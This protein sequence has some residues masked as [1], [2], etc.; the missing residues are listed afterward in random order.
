METHVLITPLLSQKA[1]KS[2][3]CVGEAA[4]PYVAP[5]SA[6][7]RQEQGAFPSRVMPSAD[8]VR[9]RVL[10][11]SDTHSALPAPSD[12]DIAYR[13]PLPRADV[14]L[15]AGDL[16]M[17]GKI[18]QHRKALELIKG[19]DAELKIVI[20]GNHDLTLDREYYDKHG[21]LHGPRPRYTETT[22]DE[23]QD[24]YTGQ[25]ARDAGIVYMVEGTRTFTL[26]NGARFTV[27]AS[28]YQP[29]FWNWAFGYPRSVDRF[30]IHAGS[31]RGAET[32]A[33]NP[34]PDAGIDIMITHG[35]PLGI[36]DRT[37]RGEDVGCKHLRRAVERCKPRLHVFGHIH[38]AAGG[39]RMDWSG[40]KE[41]I[42]QSGHKEVRDQ[43]GTYYDA[44]NLR[45][46]EQTL[47]VN[48]SIMSL[49]YVPLQS[50]WVV[51]LM[52]P[53]A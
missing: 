2:T 32:Q 51:D 17:N 39:V 44:S 16:T 30:N 22:L 41:E 10:V 9:T 18:D 27:Y 29:E 36:L 49:Q 6:V 52:L 20:P 47:F 31:D 40:T 12:G 11:L 46:G 53:H 21:E 37:S 34:V 19:V 48:A 1:L 15:H 43:M 35:P 23:I 13:W 26:R 50:P 5:R 42:G 25:E 7:E 14:L 3:P 38:E 4:E 24:L 33:E 45:S 28:A 8:E